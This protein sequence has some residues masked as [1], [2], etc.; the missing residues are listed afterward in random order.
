MTLDT[1]GTTFGTE[2][3]AASS[4]VLKEYS[5][6]DHRTEPRDRKLLKKEGKL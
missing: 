1:H 4:K 3:S 2:L 6:S 5:L